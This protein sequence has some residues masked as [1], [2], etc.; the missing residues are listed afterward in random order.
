M[1][2]TVH[3]RI[4]IIDIPKMTYKDYSAYGSTALI[5]AIGS[6]IEHIQRI[7]RYI[8]L[9]DVPDNVVFVIMTDGQE[10]SS[11]EYSSDR[12]KKMIERKKKKG[13]E[14]L[15]IGA[16][17]DAVETASGFGI[18]QNRAV[19]YHADEK[20]TKI[21]YESVACAID[22]VRTCGGLNEDWGA[23]IDAD[24]KSRKRK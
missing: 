23:N 13:W 15:F 19:N 9:E 4:S 7:H 22:S 11:R 24:Y 8:R 5:D 12:V 3:D 20:G 18:G 14:F 6:T 10:N 17:I 2:K 21:L 16:N 1:C